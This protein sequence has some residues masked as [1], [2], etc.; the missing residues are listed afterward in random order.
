VLACAN[1]PKRWECSEDGRS[2]L[3]RGCARASASPAR[4]R[5]RLPRVA[6]CWWPW[7]RHSVDSDWVRAEAAE[8]WERGALVPVRFEE[9]EPPM[10]FRQTETA[11]LAD[12]HGSKS[13]PTLLRLMDDIERVLARGAAASSDELLQRE[14]R[15]RALRRRRTL[16]RLSVAG[17]GVVAC[18]LGGLAYYA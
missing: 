1:L 14:K 8:G 3:T 2:G 5:L 12:W 6:A 13:A 4:S 11:D 15:R 16:R 7:S 18:I 9:C 10:P 17:A